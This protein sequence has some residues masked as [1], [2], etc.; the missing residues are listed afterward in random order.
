VPSSRV[1]RPDFRP[2][3]RPIGTTKEALPIL[4]ECLSFEL[5]PTDKSV[6]LSDLGRCYSEA[7]EYESARD[8]LIQALDIGIRN[9]SEGQAH[10]YLG[11]A[12]RSVCS[13]LY[14]VLRR[15]HGTN[16]PKDTAR[17][18]FLFL[19]RNREALSICIVGLAIR[20]GRSV[21]A[22]VRQL[23][24]DVQEN[25][26]E[27]DR[28]DLLRFAD[29][30]RKAGLSPRTV[31]NR[32]LAFHSFLKHFEITRITKR[33][34]APKFVEEEP[35]AYTQ[36]EITTFF[37][38][39]NPY[40]RLLFQFY[41]KTGAR[42]QEV[43]SCEWGDLNFATRQFK[44]QAKPEHDFRPKGWEE[45]SIPLEEG[46]ALALE[47]RRKAFPKGKLVFPRSLGT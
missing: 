22:G 16:Y 26:A 29:S 18:P 1:R 24:P 10:L 44:I 46:L 5:K 12:C 17:A 2:A 28:R 39:C 4:R 30:M 37:A 25:L 47:A 3:R 41:L 38:A 23:P 40:Q 6:V 43:R 15:Y 27:I 36:A 9:E 31:S 8:Y 20:N 42:M 11:I 19:N 45:R 32:W 7:E 14:D 21:P 13:D 34:D 35:E 33:G